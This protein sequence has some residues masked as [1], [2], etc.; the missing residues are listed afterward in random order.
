MKIDILFLEKYLVVR[1]KKIFNV[2]KSYKND[3]QIGIKSK[4]S[5][6]YVSLVNQISDSE[7]Y[8]NIIEKVKQFKID[9]SKKKRS[10]KSKKSDFLINQIVSLEK[11]KNILEKVKQFISGE[12]KKRRSKKSKKSNFLTNQIVSSEKY[13]NII[14]KI[15]KLKIFDSNVLTNNKD[16]SKKFD[17]K[18]GIIFYCDHNLILL[19]LIINLNNRVSITGVTEMPIPANV[20]GDSMVEDCNELA[21]IAL[22]SINLLNLDTSPLLVVLS[23]AFFN[24]HSFKLS[25]LKQISQSDS[26]VQSKSPYLPANTLVEFLKMADN[27]ISNSYVRTIYSKK[28]FIKGWTDTLEIID[29]P[30]IGLVPASTL[31]FD[32]ITK[33]VVEENTVLIDIESNSTSVLIGSELSKLNSHKLPF[34][35][36]LYISDDLKQSSKNYF[37]R[38]FNSIQLIMNAN[39]ENLPLNIFVMGPGFDQLTCQEFSLPKKFKSIADLKLSDYSYSPKKMEIHELVSDSIDSSIY[40]LTSILSSCV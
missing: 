32:S 33:K 26:K 28:D 29:L 38:V 20:I 24:I 36:S 15:K 4:K 31:I 25:D 21:N 9:E 7:K 34:G 39:N 5:E 35:S 18:I 22:D 17:Q 14:E 11:Y 30:I 3:Q 40:S 12:S 13:K 27:Q 37:D 1:F 2:F 10:K 23:S 16:K 19:S 8:K 6:V